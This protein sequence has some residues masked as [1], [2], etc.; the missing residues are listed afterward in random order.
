MITVELRSTHHRFTEVVTT[1]EV[2]DDGTHRVTGSRSALDLG[3]SMV[4]FPG[5]RIISFYDDPWLWARALPHN[6]TS[7]YLHAVIV[8]ESPRTVQSSA[9]AAG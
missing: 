9:S 7:P 2:R 5:P 3:E 4:A 1:L 8:Q 6:L